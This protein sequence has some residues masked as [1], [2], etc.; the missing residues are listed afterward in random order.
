MIDTATILG[1]FRRAAEARELLL[2]DRIEAD[3]DLHRCDVAGA[4]GKKDGA[5]VLHLDGVPAGGFENHR[6]GLGWE[7]WRADIGRRL[8][9]EEEAAH[10][11][12]IEAQRQQREAAEKARRDKARRRAHALW[13]AG[14]SDDAH[15]YL[16]RKQIRAHGARVGEWPRWEQDAAGRWRERRIPNALLVPMRSAGG[17]LHSLQAIF[18]EPVDGRDKDFLPGGQKAGCFHLVGELGEGMPLCVAEGLA[19]AASIFEPTGWPVAVAFDAGNLEAVARALREKHP[20]VPMVICAD[21]DWQTESNPGRTCAEAAARA[22]GGTVAVPAFGP[23]RPPKATDF[24]DLATS[25]REGEGIEAV[26][27]ILRAAFAAAGMSPSPAPEKS[28][29]GAAIASPQAEAAVALQIDADEGVC[30]ELRESGERPGVYRLKREP[31]RDGKFEVVE[32]FVCA[33]LAIT[34]MVRDRNGA[35]WQRLATFR[36]HDGRVRQELVPDDLLE[37]DGLALARLL[38]GRGLHIAS[39]RGGLL[40]MYVNGCRPADRA[41]LTRRIGWHESVDVAGAWSFVLG[42]EVEPI[43]A[44]GAELWLHDPQGTGHAEFRTVGTLGEWRAQVAALAVGNTR[45]SF[46]LSTGFAAGLIWLH[47]NIAGGFHW[48]GGSSLGKSAL[49]FATASL[50]GP[51]RY[52]RTWAMT[53]AAIEAT[54]AGHSDAP[55]LLDELGQSGDA[56]AVANAVYLMA[57]G[58]GK[59]RGQAAGGLRETAEFNL[60]FQSNGEV[61]LSQ[62]LAEHGE[63]DFAGQLVRFA[64]LP[65]D[66][67]AGFGCWEVLHGHADGARFSEALQRSAASCYGIA[68]PEFIRQVVRHRDTLPAQFEQARQAFERAA[69]SERAGGQVIR[70]ATRFAAVGFAG[71]LATEWGITGWPQGEAMRAAMRLFRD[72]ITAYG[73]EENRE[74]RQMVEQVRAWIQAHSSGR[75]EDW[76]RPGVTDSHAPRVMNRAGWRRPTKATAALSECDHV[77]EYLIYPHVFKAELCNGFDP[78]QVAKV[79]HKAGMLERDD[80]HMTYRTREPGA[81][82]LGRFYLLTPAVLGGDGDD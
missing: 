14:N 31:R 1:Q 72:W 62:Y 35:G 58:V 13:N 71:E 38:R 49:L 40:K 11:A 23:D 64:E 76:R 52:R 81:A 48:A 16:A 20:D 80:G 61:T 65:G 78:A 75:L 37:G 19:T 51:P 69:L 56:R 39:N 43:A 79:L 34:H 22:V 44:A 47:A 57:Q 68:Y 41:R 32:T 26:R 63:R 33:P 8:T 27:R 17:T 66:A 60:L 77:F 59:A 3:G 53:G 46:A 29:D 28:P 7:T 6:D 12:R 54:S 30:F 5:Y 50:C 21:D 55:M 4:K 9:P 18:P 67:G 10:R 73:G 82:K 74:P 45:L 2:P 36:D 24:N 25:T 15:P 70:A 42:A